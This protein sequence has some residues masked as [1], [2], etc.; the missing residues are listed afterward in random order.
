MARMTWSGLVS[1]ISGKLGGTIFSK[2]KG[3]MYMRVASAS[4]ANPMTPFQALVHNTLSDSVAI[5]KGM[6][7]VQKAEWEEYAQS[8]GSASSGDSHIGAKG[9]IPRK[10]R[11]QS[12]INAFIGANQMLLRAQYV[13]RMVPPVM[14]TPSGVAVAGTTVVPGVGYSVDMYAPDHCKPGFKTRVVIWQK[15]DRAGAHAHIIELGDVLNECPE[16]PVMQ[17]STID[18]VRVGTGHTVEAVPIADLLPINMFVQMV[19]VS[20]D[21][22]KG[23]FSPLYYLNLV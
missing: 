8:L 10:S 17:N 23:V 22:Q 2:W 20:A 11:I 5:W 12:G 21:G 1:D 15:I 19:V 4:V 7:Q 6:T 16:T 13:R 18:S 14:P 9:I 3:I